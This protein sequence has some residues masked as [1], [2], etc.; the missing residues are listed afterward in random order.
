[1]ATC[2]IGIDLGTS[3]VVIYVD[4]KGVVLDEPSVV[5]YNIKTKQL[6]AVGSEAY[7]MVGDVYKRQAICHENKGRYGYCR[8][9][10][11]LHKIGRVHV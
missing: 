10:T 2:D 5:A 4:G 3:S 1:M 7:K 11:E 6:I 8:I 9:P